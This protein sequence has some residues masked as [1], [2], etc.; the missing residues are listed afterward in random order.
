LIDTFI[1]NKR[2]SARLAATVC[3]IQYDSTGMWTDQQVGLGYY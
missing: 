1:N 3:V 2:Y